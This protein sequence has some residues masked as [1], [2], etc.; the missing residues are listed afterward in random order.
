[1]IFITSSIKY[2]PY[3]MPVTVIDSLEEYPMCECGLL[4]PPIK[5]HFRTCE[6]QTRTNSLIQSRRIPILGDSVYC[7][8]YCQSMAEI[9][10]LK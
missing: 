10:R 7:S 5:I 4:C 3:D 8:D 2:G 1:M 9:K 6:I